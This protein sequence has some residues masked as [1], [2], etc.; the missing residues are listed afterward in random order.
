M[1]LSSRSQAA[2]YLVGGSLMVALGILEI[3]LRR[4][5]SVE[6]FFMVPIGLGFVV[7]GA[8]RWYRATRDA[9]RSRQVTR[10]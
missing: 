7:F 9:I 5:P 4:F 6:A 8:W 2:F 1:K 10:H 3:A